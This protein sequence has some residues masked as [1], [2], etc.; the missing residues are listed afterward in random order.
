MKLIE[1]IH[2]AADWIVS[3]Y[4]GQLLSTATLG[5]ELFYEIAKEIDKIDLEAFHYVRTL[6]WI[7]MTLLFINRAWIGNKQKSEE[8]RK[9]KIENDRLEIQVFAEGKEALEVVHHITQMVEE[10]AQ[11]ELT[12]NHPSKSELITKHKQSLNK[13]AIFLKSIIKK[14]NPKKS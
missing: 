14:Y 9:Q 7:A 3:H 13:K 2:Y 11:H 6:F 12:Q 5:I 10:E 1:N 4:V 8:L